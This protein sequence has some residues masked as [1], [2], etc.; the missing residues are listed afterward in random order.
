MVEM[1]LFILPLYDDADSVKFMVYGDTRSYPVDHDFVNYQMINTYRLDQEYQ[2]I[3]LHVGDWVNNGD[4]EAD[5]A[6]QFFNPVYINTHEFQANIPINGCIGNHEGS[7]DLFYK[8]FPY[9][10]EPGGLYW[11]FDYGPVHIA[12]I[13]QYVDYSPGS[14]QYNWLENDLASST[15]NGSF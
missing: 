1:V 15:K 5:W 6:N 14:S 11:S 10:Y 9:L 12:V 13:D 4:L 7:G 3:T 2:T 8:Y